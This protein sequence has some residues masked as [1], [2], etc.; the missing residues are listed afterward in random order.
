MGYYTA[1]DMEVTKTKDAMLQLLRDVYIGSQLSE[2]EQLEVTKA[3]C[4]EDTSF[5]GWYNEDEAKRSSA[6]GGL[7]WDYIISA[8]TMKWYDHDDDMMQLSTQFPDYYFLLHG[9]G[10]DCDDR[11]RTVYHNGKIVCSQMIKMYFDE[12]TSLWD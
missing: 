2:E 10:E 3:L 6:H 4:G 11:W 1:F 7:A 8:D 9:Q 5:K 12:V